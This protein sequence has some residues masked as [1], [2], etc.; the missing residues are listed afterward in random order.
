M[1]AQQSH[2]QEWLNTSL[3]FWL[4]DRKVSSSHS[5]AYLW[6]V[7]S[8]SFSC[9]QLPKVCRQPKYRNLILT[10]HITFGGDIV[11]TNASLHWMT[12]QSTLYC[13]HGKTNFQNTVNL[14]NNSAQG[15][16]VRNLPEARQR[17]ITWLPSL[18]AWTSWFVDLFLFSCSQT[19]LRVYQKCVGRKDDDK[20]DLLSCMWDISDA[21]WEEDRLQPFPGG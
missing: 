19:L 12:I 9:K 21:M 3:Q 7:Y 10:A 11:N 2:K 17:A 5:A 6:I 16:E 1:I 4:W 14:P 15:A 13:A 20:C 18:A 8:H